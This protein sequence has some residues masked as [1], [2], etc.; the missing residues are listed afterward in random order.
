MIECNDL[1]DYGLKIFQN[2]EYFKFSIDSILLAEFVKVKNGMQILDFCTGNLPIPLILSTKG[3]KI[4][5]DALEIQEQIY[6]LAKKTI[7]RNK[8]ESSIQVLN[9]DIKEYSTETKYDVI[10][11]NPPYFKVSSTSQKNEN[12]IKRMARHEISINLEEIIT[13]AKRFLKETGSLY[14]VHRVERFLETIDILER[15]KFG[16]RKVVFVNT[17][18]GNNAEF[19]LIEASKYKKSDLKV[20]TIDVEGR[21]T[22]KNIFEEVNR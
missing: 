1:F 14:L 9:C 8:L 4:T 5:I 21:S 10:T 19:F 2:S 7:S 16:I 15:E 11:C 6:N 20:W 18:K 3:K 12:P 17:K 22:Y 13:H